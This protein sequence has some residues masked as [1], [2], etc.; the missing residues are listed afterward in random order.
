DDYLV[1]PFD[2]DE[3]YARIRAISRRKDRAS[4]ASGIVCGDLRLDPGS[5]K[6]WHNNLL[7]DLGPKEFRILQHL[8][9]KV[10][11]IVQKEKLQ[12]MLY[13]WDHEIESN[14]IEVHMHRIRKKLGKDTIKTIRGVGYMIEEKRK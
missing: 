3:L 7:I 14:A 10:G 5:L 6:A 9:E 2:L 4:I 1:K 12:E 11:K 8:I 13:S